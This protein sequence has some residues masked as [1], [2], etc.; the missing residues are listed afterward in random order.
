M[1]YKPATLD[2]EPLCV[3]EALD[4]RFNYGPARLEQALASEE[5]GPFATA[6]E[7]EAARVRALEEAK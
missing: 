1:A 2:A 3:V 7:A 5:T 4:G 6:E